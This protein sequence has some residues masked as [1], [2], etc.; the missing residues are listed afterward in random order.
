M[1]RAAFN[2]HDEVVSLLLQAGA[3]KDIKNNDGYTALVACEAY[4][5]E[6]TARQNIIKMLEDYKP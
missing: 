1:H 4:C 5:N 6:G 2:G 3:D